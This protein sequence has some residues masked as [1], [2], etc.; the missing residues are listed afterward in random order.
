MIEENDKKLNYRGLEYFL[1]KLKSFFIK[2]PKNRAAGKY[3]RCIDSDGNVEW[4]EFPTFLTFKGTVTNY[5]QLP[6]YNNSPGDVWKVES[7]GAEYY[8]ALNQAGTAYSWEYL[9]KLVN[10]T[11]HAE[12]TDTAEVGQVLVSKSNEPSGIT[13]EWVSRSDLDTTYSEGSNVTIDINSN[14][15]ISAIGYRYN[16]ELH[17]FAEGEGDSYTNASGSNSHAEGSYTTAQNETEHAEGSYNMSHNDSNTYGSSGNTQHSVGIGD[18]SIKKNAFEIMQNGDM[19]VYGVGGYVGR[20]TK[21]QDSNIKPLQE[22]LGETNI[23]ESI[24]VN[25]NR[26]TVINKNVNITVPAQ[27]Q[28]DWKATS[29]MAQILNK[30]S[31]ADVATSGS[32]NDLSDK[33]TIPTVPSDVSAFT[34][35]AGYITGYTE[36]DPVFTAS[37]A[38]SIKSTD[39]S[40]WNSKQPAGNYKTIQT[41][42]NDPTA[43]STTSTTFIDSIKQDTNGVITATKKTIPNIPQG[44]VTSITAGYGLLGGTITNSGTIQLDEQLNTAQSVPS[45]ESFN[46]FKYNGLYNISSNTTITVSGNNSPKFRE[47]IYLLQNTGSSD[48]NV[49]IWGGSGTSVLDMCSTSPIS[50]PAGHYCEIVFTCWSNSLVTYN[51]GISL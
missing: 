41:A 25:G 17:S 43:S 33:P 38:A 42:I 6:S 49:T 13:Y 37:P 47:V 11:K 27:V 31:L 36:L 2:N 34:N 21:V 22:S 29:G 50:I 9:G 40:N 45:T 39:I 44:T 51:Y 28:S 4:A 1:E 32:Y 19:Y 20:N 15:A 35:D 7:T 12:I 5:E 8:W 3:L 26:Q 16:A 24:S 18:R 30:P 48:I 23:I 14:N 46:N 10:L